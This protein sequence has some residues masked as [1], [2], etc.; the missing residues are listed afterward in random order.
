M[1]SFNISPPAETASLL[2][3]TL[4]KFRQCSTT[5]IPHF[6]TVSLSNLTISLEDEI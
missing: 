5:T 1:N 6:S 2:A 3:A 4:A